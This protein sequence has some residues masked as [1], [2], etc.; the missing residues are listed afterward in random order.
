MLKCGECTFFKEPAPGTGGDC[1]HPEM[2]TDKTFRTHI[3]LNYEDDC[4]FGYC[5][6]WAARGAAKLVHIAQKPAKAKPE[7]SSTGCSGCV[8]VQMAQIPEMI[9]AVIAQSML[10][11]NER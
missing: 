4:R 6:I 5:D 7:M 10:E 8:S 11:L 3:P 9:G 1:E 2:H